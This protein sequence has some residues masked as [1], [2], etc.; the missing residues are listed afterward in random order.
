[1]RFFWVLLFLLSF[2]CVAADQE[3]IGKVKTYKPEAVIIHNGTEV[4]AT[5]DTSIYAGDQIVTRAK[6]T[7]GIIFIDG[8]VLTLGPASRFTIDKFTFNPAD[9]DVS[10]I[11]TIIK[12]TV[13]FISGAIGR[14]SPESVKFKTPTATLGLRGTKILVEVK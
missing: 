5:V 1:M 10:F 4:E 9:N 14:I 13:S 8:A 3:P 7:V 11:S 6:G 2:S 12:G